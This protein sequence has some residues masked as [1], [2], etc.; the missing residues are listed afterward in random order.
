MLNLRFIR[1]QLTA[2]KQQ[3][4]I[5]VVCVALSMVSLVALRGLGDSIN[6]ALL[7]DA[8]ELQAS[9]II[10]ESNFGLSEPVQARIDALVAAGEA[11]AARLWEFYTVARLPDREETLLVNIKAVEPGYPFYGQV[12]LASGRAF[13]DVLAPGD[14]IVE[15][16]LLDRLGVAV[17]DQLRLGEPLTIADVVT[18][19]PDRPVNFFA[20]GPRICQRGR[21]GGAG[22]GARGQ[23]GQLHHAAQG[24]RRRATGPRSPSLS[25][26]RRQWA[27]AWRRT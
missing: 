21:S 3:S 8:R 6:R 14:V 22:S 25:A 12:E 9:D 11:Q 20:L 24:G 27:R 10:V 16:A 19:E 13:A 4:A 26:V 1:R 18:H 7:T 2:T 17:G 5:F 23:P 15:Q